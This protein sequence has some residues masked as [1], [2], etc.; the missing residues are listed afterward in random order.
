[1]NAMLIPVSSLFL[2]SNPGMLQV[3]GL[4][5]LHQERH[6]LGLVFPLFL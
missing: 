4:V 5:L 6:L 3:Q 1:M 2:A